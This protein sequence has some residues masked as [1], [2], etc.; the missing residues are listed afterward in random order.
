MDVFIGEP[1]GASKG[2]ARIRGIVYA[3]ISSPILIGI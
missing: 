2:R 1:K 3:R